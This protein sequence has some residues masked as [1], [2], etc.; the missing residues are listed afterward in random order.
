MN[1]IVDDN[2]DDNYDGRLV[3]MFLNSWLM[4][5]F[6]ADEDEKGYYGR[7]EYYNRQLFRK[8][9]KKIAIER[10]VQAS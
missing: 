5:V 6:A 3:F 4:M 8:M 7:T 2:Y 9:K 1:N 10:K